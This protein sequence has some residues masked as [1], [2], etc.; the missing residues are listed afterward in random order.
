[1]SLI[2]SVV[3]VISTTVPPE[4]PLSAKETVPSA[5]FARKN[6]AKV[7]SL[8]NVVGSTIARDSDGVIYTHAGLEIGVASTKAYMSQII[9]IFFLAL[10][11]SEVRGEDKSLNKKLIFDELMSISR[12]VSRVLEDARKIKQCAGKY[13]KYSGAFYLGRHFN[14][15]TALEGALK[16]KEIS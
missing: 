8:C 11:L 1:M 6:G 9:T 4:P 5:L 16:N 14:Y 15:P 12:K 7:L 3:V 10:Y 13:Y 2:V